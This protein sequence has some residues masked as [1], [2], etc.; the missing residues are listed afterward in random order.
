MPNAECRMSSSRRRSF[1]AENCLHLFGAIGAGFGQNS[2][3]FA[4]LLQARIGLK[5]GRAAGG[6]LNAVQVGCQRQASPSHLQKIPIQRG[7]SVLH[8][9]ILLRPMALCGMGK[10]S[11][12]SGVTS[13]LPE[14]SAAVDLFSPA[15]VLFSRNWPSDADLEGR[16]FCERR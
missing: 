4:K 16:M 15:A 11:A 7:F 2:K 1:V 6:F 13:S 8:T 5:Q 9:F 3:C 10:I 12:V 14:K